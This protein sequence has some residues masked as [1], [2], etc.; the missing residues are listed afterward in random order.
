M[1]S[2][3]S[4]SHEELGFSTGP[5]IALISALRQSLGPADEAMTKLWPGAVC[6]NLMD[7]SLARDLSEAGGVTKTIIRRFLTLS[8]YAESANGVAGSTVGILYTCSAFGPAIDR[9]RAALSIPV[10]TPNEG[11]FE[12]AL[13]I[14]LGVFGGGHVGLLLSFAGSADPLT[15]ELT[16]MASE[17]DQAP[18]AISAVVAEGALVALQSGRSE[19]HDELIANA[20]DQLPPLDVLIIG[21]FSMARSA[22]LVAARRQ[23]PVLTTPEGAVRKL[24]RL[25]ETEGVETEG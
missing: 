10:V 25:V 8:R 15:S 12:E 20:A 1:I 23:E 16:R 14:C 2:V 9:A 3:Q 11:A 18:P 7:D 22:P 13:D 19:L 17:R 4:K 24:R 5:R 21:Q 6:F